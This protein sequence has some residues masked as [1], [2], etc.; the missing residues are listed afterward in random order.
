MTQIRLPRSDG[1]TVIHDLGE[2][3]GHEKP[4]G[5]VEARRAFAAVHV[6]ADPL[7][8]NTPGSSA[9]VDWDATLAFRRHIWSWGLAVA[10]AMDT[11]QRGMGMG[12]E[13]TRELITRTSA[14]AK[15]EGGEIACGANTD[16]LTAAD[17]SLA[18][19]IDAYQ[20]QV[21]L[22][23]DAGGQ[24]VVMASRHLAAV[25]QGEDDYRQVYSEV[26]D[27]AQRPVL[28]HWLGGM[29]DPALSEYWG[30]SDLDSATECFLSILKANVEKV[31]GVKI[32]LLEKEREIDM[33]RRLPAG[34]RM[35]TGDDFNYPE[36]IGGDGQHHS[37]A[38]LGAFDVIAPAASAAIQ[39]LDQ[40]DDERFRE[41]LD[42]TLPLARHVFSE[43]TFNYKTGVVFMAYLN[44]HQDHFRM[45][46]AMESARSVLHLVDQFLLADQAGLLDDPE[47]A[48]YRMALVLELAGC[49]QD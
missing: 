31:D 4:T 2:P 8:D 18:E 16:Q 12:W 9:V 5:P 38:F 11:A 47:L 7:A 45:V 13:P 20:E 49:P 28:I 36:V 10:D 30:S 26:L 22:I 14:E 34:L 25:A 42:P 27:S 15:A 3:A 6:V 24:A 29:F 32:S 35:Y 41:I 1:T 43:P 33:R 40:G 19:I 37:D 39:V 44:G 23:E 48:S 21:A 17:P 46:A